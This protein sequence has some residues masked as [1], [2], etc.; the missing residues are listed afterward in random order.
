MPQAG[1]P[2]GGLRGVGR[3]QEV[4]L[5]PPPLGT[6]SGPLCEV[7][8][9]QSLPSL[10]FHALLRNKRRRG[11]PGAVG[12]LREAPGRARG[13]DRRPLRVDRPMASLLLSLWDQ[14][15]PCGFTVLQPTPQPSLS[16][17][18]PWPFFPVKL[19]TENVTAKCRAQRPLTVLDSKGPPLRAKGRVHSLDGAA[20]LAS[21]AHGVACSL[22][23][24]GDS[25]AKSEPWN[26]RKDAKGRLILDANLSPGRQHTPRMEL[27]E[28]RA[29]AQSREP[30][31]GG[32][33]E[34]EAP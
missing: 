13:E 18:I 14:T 11:L 24:A 31:E 27:W 3:A 5:L 8:A 6:S 26:H 30:G 12:M 23:G 17:S 9:K 22:E 10:D 15:A 28:P 33:A 25:L 19:S 20:S 16:R 21:W 1:D 29:Q 4:W 32:G 34:R 7:R 2:D